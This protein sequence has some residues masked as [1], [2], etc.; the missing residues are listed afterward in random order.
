MTDHLAVLEKARKVVSSE[1]HRRYATGWMDTDELDALLSE[2]DAAIALMRGQSEGDVETEWVVTSSYA[3][4]SGH[5]TFDSEAKAFAHFAE[6]SEI[7]SYLNPE[8]K[9]Q[10]QVYMRRTE[11]TD[12]TAV[13]RAAMQ[14]TE[15]K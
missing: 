14:Q 9:R 6:N 7:P 2:M 3:G 5:P 10:A 1:R 11:L 8:R 4:T 12:V 15:K 13:A